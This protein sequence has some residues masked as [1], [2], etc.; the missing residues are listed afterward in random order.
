M[1]HKL[2]INLN[3]EGFSLIEVL[4]AL[5]IFMFIIGGIVMFS[6]N[7]IKANTRSQSMQESIDNARYAIDDLTK[8]IRTSSNIKLTGNNELFFIDNRTLTK[9]CY[10]FDNN[11]MT[12]ARFEPTIGPGGSMTPQAVNLYNA[13]ID[14]SSLS[15]TKPIVGGDNGKISV[16]GKFEVMQTNIIDDNNPHRGFVRIIIDIVYGNVEAPEDRSEVHLQSGVS[17][18]DYEREEEVKFEAN[19]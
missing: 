18:A 15:I 12:V 9:Y 2:E 3:C 1:R 16:N 6:V 10:R 11:Q 5:A 7:S 4:I 14:C 13:V 8:K 19:N 17:I